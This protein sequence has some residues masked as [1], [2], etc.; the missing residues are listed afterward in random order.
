LELVA[1]IDVTDILVHVFK[2]LDGWQTMYRLPRERSQRGEGAGE[3]IF[4]GIV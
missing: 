1:L 4:N 2:T 3:D